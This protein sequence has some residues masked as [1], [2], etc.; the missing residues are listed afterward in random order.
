MQKP[1]SVAACAVSNADVRRVRRAS[2]SGQE[3]VL[4]LGQPYG[5]AASAET[6]AGA[7]GVPQPVVASYPLVVG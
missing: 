5:I 7:F 4:A 6:N 3:Y 2:A 1:L